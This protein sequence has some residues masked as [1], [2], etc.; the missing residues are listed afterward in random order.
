MIFIFYRPKNPITSLKGRFLNSALKKGE[1]LYKG[2]GAF[3][4]G[5]VHFGTVDKKIFEGEYK[6]FSA[7]FRQLF[8]INRRY[9]AAIQNSW[10][11]LRRSLQKDMAFEKK[12]K[13]IASQALA[14][15]AVMSFF[16]F[17]FAGFF[18]FSLEAP[19]PN[20]VWPVMIIMVS[21]AWITYLFGMKKI[22]DRQ[23]REAGPLLKT[24]LLVDSLSQTG[25]ASTEV[26]EKAE[27]SNIDQLSDPDFLMI[28]S[29]FVAATNA[30]QK[31]GYPIKNTIVEL[32]DEF[33]FMMEQK[34]EKMTKC[35]QALQL[36]CTFVFILPTFFF[37]VSTGF[38]GFMIE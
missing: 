20:F 8:E 32:A 18:S 29:Q 31:K 24:L 21:L 33:W 27:S 5:S 30:W 23:W 7:A 35:L 12:V 16:L 13:S 11:D 2:V 34:L 1:S 19:L 25:M 6:F 26:L 4:P 17:L 15:M 3:V 36:I 22:K 14:Q 28:K 9:G 37:L 38:S 10:R